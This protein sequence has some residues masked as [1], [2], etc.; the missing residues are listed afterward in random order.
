MIMKSIPKLMIVG[1]VAIA[2]AVLNATVTF[3]QTTPANQTTPNE[4]TPANQP[5]PNETTPANQAT[6]ESAATFTCA[7]SSNPP[8]TYMLA[9]DERGQ[10]T[11]RPIFSWHSEYL[12]PGASAETLCQQTAQKL[13]DKYDRGEQGYP[14]SL[15]VATK[16]EATGETSYRMDVCLVTSEEE[17]CDNT[18]QTAM[19]FS[20]NGS[21][22]NTLA[23][24]MENTQP[25]VCK[26]RTRGSVMALPGASYKRFWFF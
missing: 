11:L 1:T 7:T 13:Q 21:Y 4:T 15:L 6:P 3:S 18:N 22:N 2:L 10:S 20:L 8:I 23:C 26:P 14:A 12:L 25:N 5:A 19:L 16:D 24:V 9:K 17:T